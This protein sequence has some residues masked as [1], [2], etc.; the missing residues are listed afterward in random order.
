MWKLQVQCADS[1]KYKIYSNYFFN[2]T[3]SNHQGDVIRTYFCP[4]EIYPAHPFVFFI[5]TTLLFAHSD[6]KL[7]LVTFMSTMRFYKLS[8]MITWY[9]YGPL[10]QF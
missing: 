5:K 1:T 6:K 7:Q 9:I 4:L 10:G 8:C 3:N 2:F